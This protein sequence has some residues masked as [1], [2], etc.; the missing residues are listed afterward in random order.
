MLKFSILN[1]QFSFYYYLCRRFP[2]TKHFMRVMWLSQNMGK[3][4]II[5]HLTS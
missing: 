4:M 3:P 1:P 2:K 5:S